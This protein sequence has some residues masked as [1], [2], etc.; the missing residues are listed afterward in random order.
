MK[1][2]LYRLTIAGATLLLVLPLADCAPTLAQRGQL[3]PPEQLAQLKTGTMTRGDV[4]AKIGTPTSIA[5]FDD[6]TWYYIGEDTSQ[7]A[8]FAP[9]II[10]RRVVQLQFDKDG[11]LKTINE[12]TAKDAQ[13]V[14]VAKQTTRVDGEDPTVLQQ[15][16]GNVGRYDGPNDNK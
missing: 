14:P 12:K 6:T 8:F 10:Q 11:L 9:K 13:T 1:L 15:L 5:P 7:S 3:V 2:S 16:I 4:I